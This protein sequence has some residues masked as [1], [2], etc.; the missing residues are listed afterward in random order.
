MISTSLVVDGIYN[1]RGFRSVK[2]DYNSTIIDTDGQMTQNSFV[3]LDTKNTLIDVL[4]PVEYD[5]YISELLD[6]LEGRKIDNIVLNHFEIDDFKIVEKLILEFPD[7]NIYISSKVV[8]DFDDKNKHLKIT[9]VDSNSEVSTGKFTFEFIHTPFIHTKEH[10]ITYIKE[11]KM[12]FSNDIFG[13]TVDDLIHFDHDHSLEY[14][15]D[16]AKMFYANILLPRAKFIKMKLEKLS[17]REIRY[18]CPTFGIVWKDYI[19]DIMAAYYGW[20]TNE[21]ENKAVLVYDSALGVTEKM[22]GHVYKAL[23]D[24][25]F[26]VKV[27]KLSEVSDANVMSELIDARAILVGSSAF[28]G[29][30]DPAL[31]K[32]LE[33]IYALKPTKMYGYVFGTFS[34]YQGH[35]KRVELRLHEAGIEVIDTISGFLDVN[36]DSEEKAYLSASEFAIIISRK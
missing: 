16:H 30:M 25:G 23:V 28:H 20:V 14:L 10:M 5:M 17:K 34:E 31:A 8:D 21:K 33:R 4:R 7:V 24:S 11:E 19:N 1:I 32:L 12:L 36:R 3:V 2:Y 15:I 27:C 26:E 9:R 22:S 35:I 13:T 29:A 18:I 6:I